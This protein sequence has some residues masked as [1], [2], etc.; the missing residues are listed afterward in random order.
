MSCVCE[1]RRAIFEL[2]NIFTW[3]GFFF[4]LIIVNEEKV[5]N[6]KFYLQIVKKIY[7]ARCQSEKKSENWYTYQ[8]VVCENACHVILHA[9]VMYLAVQISHDRIAYR[10]VHGLVC[11]R[12]RDGIVVHLISN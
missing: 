3:A 6:E 10:V 2:T 1:S 9:P 11:Q 4:S 7:F 8:G 12:F 5:Y